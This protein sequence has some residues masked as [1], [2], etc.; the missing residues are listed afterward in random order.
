MKLRKGRS[1]YKI[2]AHSQV[3]QVFIEGNQRHNQMAAL[4][5]CQTSLE[6]LPRQDIWGVPRYFTVSPESI[7]FA[8]A[9][10]KPYVVKV[11]Y[12]P[13]IQEF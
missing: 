4:M 3:F 1:H 13:P 12:A 9:P 7:S 5:L 2:P 6:D 10:D 8:P 11:R